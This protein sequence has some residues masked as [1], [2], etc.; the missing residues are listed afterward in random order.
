MVRT[1]V[2]VVLA[3]MVA[4]CGGAPFTLEQAQDLVVDGSTFAEASSL[5]EASTEVTDG[6]D[7]DAGHVVGVAHPEAGAPVDAGHPS[8][9][10][11][12]A[13]VVDAGPQDAGG[14]VA[15]GWS[16]CYPLMPCASCA[17]GSV[18][19]PGSGPVPAQCIPDGTC[20]PNYT[21]CPAAGDWCPAAGQA[22]VCPYSASADMQC[23]TPADCTVLGWANV[24]AYECFE[25]DC[26]VATCAPGCTQSDQNYGCMCPDGG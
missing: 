22:C 23:C 12:S 9:H 8:S 14:D 3:V 6:A 26:Y 7:T 17:V 11:A 19:C 15:A 4:G 2:L 16:N 21:V 18:F 24:A 25:N 5:P 20:C 13:V 10:D 1:L